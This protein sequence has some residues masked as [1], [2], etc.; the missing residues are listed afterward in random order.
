MAR[1]LKGSHSFT[2][3]TRLCMTQTCDHMNHNSS[4]LPIALLPPRPPHF[5]WSLLSCFCTDLHILIELQIHPVEV[6]LLVFF[7]PSPV[8]GRSTPLPPLSI[9]FVIFSP[10]YFSLSFIGFTCFL[11]LSIP[12][13]STRIVP[14]RF[15]ARGHMRRLNLG[16]VCV[17]LCNLCYLYFLVKTDCGVLFYLCFCECSFSAL[18]LLVGSF[19]L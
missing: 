10:I 17:L 11:L 7:L 2:C 12:S 5:T 1:V 19:D 18:T 15:Q 14:L 16:L 6:C 3:T 8:W 9:Y 4:A 13:L